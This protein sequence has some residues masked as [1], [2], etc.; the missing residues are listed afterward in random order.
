MTILLWIPDSEI[1]AEYVTIR[2][3]GHV[4]V[5]GVS[6]PRKY[7]QGMGQSWHVTLDGKEVS[8]GQDFRGKAKALAEQTVRQLSK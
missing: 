8:G 5:A 6:A 2:H 1:G 3:G 7:P 4:I